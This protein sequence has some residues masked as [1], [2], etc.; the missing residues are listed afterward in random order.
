MASGRQSRGP[1]ATND[2]PIAQLHHLLRTVFAHWLARRYC[3]LFYTLLLNFVAFPVLAVLGFDQTPMACL[4]AISLAVA[5]VG[6]RNRHLSH[7]MLILLGVM[8]AVRI[9]AGS[10]DL[11]GVISASTTL[12][13]VLGFVA[14]IDTVRVAMS[15]SRVNAELLYA[16]LSVY[17]LVGILF[18]VLY[19]AVAM[20]NPNAFS[21]P[22]GGALSM[23][24]G[25]YFS[26]VTQ[27]TLGYGDILP[28]SDVARGLAA[29][30]AVAGQFYLSVMVARLVSLYV[31]ARKSD[32]AP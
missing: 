17:L 18:A 31:S 2:T 25:V 1:A 16:A 21:L 30:Q 23:H 13:V 20:A 11:H 4:V 28:R 8:L 27:T 15:S 24:T 26:F 9:V 32:G 19:S 6:L 10:I 22:E 5:L 29:V 12:L 14:G 3:V 7:L